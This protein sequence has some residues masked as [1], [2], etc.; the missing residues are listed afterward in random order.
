MRLPDPDT[1]TAAIREAA[2]LDV[3]PRFRALEKDEVKEKAP[4]DVVTQADIDAEHRLT[5]SLTDLLPGS[6]VVGEEAFAQDEAVLDRFGG[7]DA[8]WIVDPVDGTAN[9]AAGKEQ[10]C[11]MVALAVG[12]APRMSWIHDPINNLTAIAEQG[13]GAF[14]GGSRLRVPPAPSIEGMSGSI[15]IG[16]WPH[17]ERQKLRARASRFASVLSLRCAGL[18]FLQLSLGER[19]FSV[20]RRL[21]PWDHVPGVLLFA[22]AGGAVRRMDGEPYRAR[23]RVYGLLSAAD[24]EAWQSVRDYLMAD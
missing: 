14:Y 13:A 4:G 18:D 2:E 8:V 21:W 11:M 7:S 24:E 10:F 15:N 6:E 23:D 5:R 22:E 19:H 17:D 12:G 20:F 9:F 16:F 3:L 1:V